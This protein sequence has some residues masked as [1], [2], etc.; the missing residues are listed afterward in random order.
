MKR[1]FID[2]DNLQDGKEPKK[3]SHEPQE[4]KVDVQPEKSEEEE[5][6]KEGGKTEKKSEERIKDTSSSFQVEKDIDGVEFDESIHVTDKDG[7][8]KKTKTGKFR[9]KRNAKKVEPLSGYENPLES[10][11]G[12]KEEKTTPEQQKKKEEEK[13]LYATISGETFLNVLDIA[14]SH[15]IPKV[16]GFIDKR[17]KKI[18][19]NNIRLTEQDKK[20][21]AEIAGEVSKQVFGNMS[22]MGQLLIGLTVIY[23]S[24][25]STE[26]GRLKNG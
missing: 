17:A 7:K 6:E 4:S 24:N 20:D 25:V 2:V 26:I 12:Y 16:Y 11:A 9:K 22:P 18:D 14:F 23:S 5:A 3:S 15:L 19:S 21:L 1:E 10:Y 13:K 8:P